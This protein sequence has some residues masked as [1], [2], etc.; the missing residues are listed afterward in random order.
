M[1]K[2]WARAHAHNDYMHKRPLWDALDAGF[3][4]VEADIYVVDE[5]LHVA[6]DRKDI[7]AEG[8]LDA[9]YLRPLWERFRRSKCIQPNLLT[10]QLLVD[11][12]ADAA[13]ALKILDRTL[14]PYEEMLSHSSRG[15]YSQGAVEIVLSGDRPTQIL[16]GRSTR[17]VFLDAR[18]VDISSAPVGLFVML[19]ESWLPNIPWYGRGMI[20]KKHRQWL[21]DYVAKADD[22]GIKSRFW[23]IPDT[24]SAWRLLDAA[25]VSWIGTDQLTICSEWFMKRERQ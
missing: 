14:K 4:S 15:N 20:T 13:G 2:V 1:L 11:I 10:F 5:N 7:T 18:M 25:G 8:T 12:K 23:G 24:P 21:S 9:M 16:K 19:S 22:L 3:A 6:H 17:N